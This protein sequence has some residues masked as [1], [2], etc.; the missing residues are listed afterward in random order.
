MPPHP[1]NGRGGRFGEGGRVAAGEGRAGTR[2]GQGHL[3]D[4]ENAASTPA[5]TAVSVRLFGSRD[6]FDLGLAAVR[7]QGS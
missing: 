7:G 1:S 5:E 2:A 4:T 3:N 6:C